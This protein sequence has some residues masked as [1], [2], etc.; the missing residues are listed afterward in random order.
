MAVI[1]IR[2]NAR[3]AWLTGLAGLCA[4]ARDMARRA[5][6]CAAAAVMICAV[7]AALL[8]L[9]VEIVSF[10]AP[11]AAV[12]ITVITAALLNVLCRGLRARAR[13]R[14]GPASRPGLHR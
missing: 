12:G 3:A 10:P 6:A 2:G 4:T 7:G 1:V 11:I 9:A 14:H 5:L 8:Q 13:H